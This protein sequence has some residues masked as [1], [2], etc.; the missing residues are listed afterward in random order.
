MLR[1]AEAEMPSPTKG[2]VLQG[3][4]TLPL[5]LACRT[6]AKVGAKLALNQESN[7]AEVK[8]SWARVG[9]LTLARGGKTSNV[10]R[11]EMYTCRGMLCCRNPCFFTSRELQAFRR[12]GND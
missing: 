4:D 11:A 6:V 7:E 12:V 10:A 8:V 1:M 9:S 2:M 3:N 5:T